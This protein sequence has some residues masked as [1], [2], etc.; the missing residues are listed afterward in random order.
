[1]DFILEN[2]ERPVPDPN[3]APIAEAK[4]DDDEEEQQRKELE[5]MAEEEE[6]DEEDSEPTAKRRRIEPPPAE[7]KGL[8]SSDTIE[9]LKYFAEIRK[10]HESTLV[11]QSAPPPPKALALDYGSDD[12]E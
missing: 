10:R 7:P 9:G 6:S 8:L 4:D 12:D 5:A 11:K 1:M 2:Q 3:S